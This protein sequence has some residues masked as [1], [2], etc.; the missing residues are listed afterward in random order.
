[1]EKGADWNS[2]LK[3]VGHWFFFIV[4]AS[5][6]ILKLKPYLLSCSI[7]FRFLQYHQS[8]AMYI[9]QFIF[10][11]TIRIFYSIHVR[12]VQNTIKP[13]YSKTHIISQICLHD[14]VH[15]LHVYALNMFSW[16]LLFYFFC[17]MFY[18]GNKI[19]F[20]FFHMQ[21]AIFIKEMNIYKHIAYTYLIFIWVYITW[22]F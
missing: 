11:L 16:I 2:L 7:I 3:N 4:Y 15:L 6:R 9:L 20:L 17:V 12:N 13:I 19:L 22:T 21:W 18:K 1:M 10:E 8:I 14:C 5:I